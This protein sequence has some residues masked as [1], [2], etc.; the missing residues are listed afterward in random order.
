MKLET[1]T[2]TKGLKILIQSLYWECSSSGEHM[3]EAHGVRGPTPRI[4]ILY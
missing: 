3:T 2:Q 4:P 1:H